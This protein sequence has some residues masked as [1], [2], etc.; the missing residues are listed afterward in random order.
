MSHFFLTLKHSHSIS[1]PPSL[2]LSLSLTHTHSGTLSHTHSL[3]LSCTLSVSPLTLSSAFSILVRTH[4]RSLTPSLS[5]TVS[6]SPPL[7][8]HSL[9]LSLAVNPY[10]SKSETHW[11]CIQVRQGYNE[12]RKTWG[13]GSFHIHCTS[14]HSA[15]ARAHRDSALRLQQRHGPC[16]W[17]RPPLAP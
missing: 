10:P 16:K 1:L 15:P 5:H 17:R 4:T 11:H 12:G 13:S 7:I 9:S 3:T 14:Q 2:P 8:D 6:L